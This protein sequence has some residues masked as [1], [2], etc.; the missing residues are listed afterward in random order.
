MYLLANKT[1]APNFLKDKK[2][3]SPETEIKNLEIKKPFKPR[4]IKKF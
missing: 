4:Y 3:I 1:S 2:M